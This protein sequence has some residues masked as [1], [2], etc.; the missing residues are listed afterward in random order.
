MSEKI[1]YSLLNKFLGGITPEE[2]ALS[3]GKEK[4][5]QTKQ[6][7][8]SIDEYINNSENQLNQ[9]VAKSIRTK[10]DIDNI[11]F[12][13][14]EIS[15]ESYDENLQIY[16]LLRYMSPLRVDI[17]ESVDLSGLTATYLS[18]LTLEDKTDDEKAFFD[19]IFNLNHA[20]TGFKDNKPEVLV[21]SLT[22][23]AANKDLSIKQVSQWFKV[24]EEFSG[25][26]ILSG[27][28]IED[29]N[30]IYNLSLIET[31]RRYFELEKNY[32]INHFSELLN[33]SI[34]NKYGD[35]LVEIV[36]K[37]FEF[38]ELFHGSMDE[39]INQEQRLPDNIIIVKNQLRNLATEFVSSDQ[40]AE[41]IEEID[42][43]YSSID[44]KS[45]KLPILDH[46]S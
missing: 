7:S 11:D 6:P 26:Q 24:I 13:S 14:D 32:L 8:M 45:M 16:D 28:S 17:P 20:M 12:D 3:V 22:K 10:S 37:T 30:L 35:V 39:E 25:Y 23:I 19:T 38:V 44:F 9:I 5:D 33:K 31:K 21:E 43:F 4:S 29:G 40:M 41:L 2:A 27:D 36:E 1:D 18:N 46:K 15:T 34:G 42:G